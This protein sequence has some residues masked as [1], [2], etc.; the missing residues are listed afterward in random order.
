MK[1]YFDGCSHT[2][3]SE[4]TDLNSRYSK[5]ICNHYGAEEYNIAERGGS[6]K[7]MVRNLFL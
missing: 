1:I 6:D 7:R 4:L 2:W 3:G 5:I